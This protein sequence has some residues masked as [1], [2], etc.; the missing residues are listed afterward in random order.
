[1]NT[2]EIKVLIDSIGNNLIR[3]YIYPSEAK[4][5]YKSICNKYKSGVYNKTVNR[6]ELADVIQSDIQ[7]VHHDGH[8]H[9]MYNPD[10]EKRLLTILPDSVQKLH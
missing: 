9:I 3:W 1:M 7:K 10:S 4:L 8:M 5:I 2:K 6:S